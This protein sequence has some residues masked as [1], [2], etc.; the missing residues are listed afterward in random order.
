MKGILYPLIGILHLSSIIFSSLSFTI[1]LGVI[2]AG[3]VASALIGVV[4]FMPLALIL[5]FVKKI[6][7]SRKI[8]HIMGLIWV[9]SVMTLFIAEV[10]N[11][12]LI[13]MIST[14]VFV[15]VTLSTTVL[16]FLRILTKRLIY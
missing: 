3:L 7:I 12:P 11:S 16:T 10:S 9:G 15:L 13:M 14:S 4:Y 5:S 6:K 1:E 8:I 2:L